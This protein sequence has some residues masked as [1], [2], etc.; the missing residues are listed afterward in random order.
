MDSSFAVDQQARLDFAYQA[1]ERANRAAKRLVSRYYGRAP[2]YAYF[3]G[4]STG[5]REAMLAAQRLPLEFDGVVAGNPAFNLTRIAANQ[6]WSLQTVTRVAP[7]D[8]NGRPQLYKAFTDP[9]LQAVADAV[10]A[11]CDSLDGLADGMI[12]DFQACDFDPASLQCTAA[13]SSS[14][15]QCLSD[16]QVDALKDIFGGARNSQGEPLY[17]EFPFDTGI[18]T[19]AWRGMH[20]GTETRPPA[21]AF[22]GRDTLRMFAM[23]PA[24]PDL[25]PLLFDFDRDMPATA[26]TAA[27]NDAVATL[28]SSFAGNGGKLIVYHGLSD[29][30]MATGALTQWYEALTPRGGDGPQSWARLFLVPGM[31]HCGGGESTD[32]FDM[33]TAIQAWVENDD[34]PERVIAAGKAFDGITRP[35]CPYPQVARYDG[36]DPGAEESFACR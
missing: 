35:L 26:E 7:R 13:S 17:G 33:L 30:G 18:A 27:T 4:C 15:Q 23:T 28:H 14:D 8:A 3:M 1:V 29:Q 34:A 19:A 5:G 22:L 10:T 31:T 24:N 25:D 36:G 9:Q 2:E 21:N 6:V 12:N 32:Q 20:L 16:R 11:Q